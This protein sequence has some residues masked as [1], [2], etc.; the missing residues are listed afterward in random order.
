MSAVDEL[1]ITTLTAPDTSMLLVFRDTVQI[2]PVPFP[3]LEISV[4][5]GGII[6]L[7]HEDSCSIYTTTAT[8]LQHVTSLSPPC[9]R[10]IGAGF[11]ADG[12]LLL[13]E[14]TGRRG[15]TN[16]SH[17]ALTDW[18]TTD[19]TMP[20]I[21][22]RY[23]VRSFHVSPHML[24]VLDTQHG[25]HVTSLQ[26]EN[27]FAGPMYPAGFRLI[28]DVTQHIEEET[29]LDYC[30]TPPIHETE[31]LRHDIRDVFTPKECVKPSRH[32]MR[33]LE[34]CEPSPMNF[35]RA[36]TG[37]QCVPTMQKRRF[38]NGAHL[39]SPAKCSRFENSSGAIRPKHFHLPLRVANGDV[40]RKLEDTRHVGTIP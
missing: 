40:F 26:R 32:G 21:A 4:A 30:P 17:Y 33:V 20:Q 6:M 7:R 25:V 27:F 19:I 9:S 39:L 3:V 35:W 38:Q 29:D 1:L 14:D 34:E 31:L 13:T 36:I 22:K 12:A 11:A 15:C 23:A 10:V 28:M 24:V 2:S 37:G 16:L 5:P 8:T 18:R